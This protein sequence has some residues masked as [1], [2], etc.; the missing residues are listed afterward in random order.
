MSQS[1]YDWFKANS[2]KEQVIQNLL[3]VQ[4]DHINDPWEIIKIPEV[5]I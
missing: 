4:N 3:K 5:S 2:T 1:E